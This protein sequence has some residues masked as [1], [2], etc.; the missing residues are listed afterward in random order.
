M[1]ELFNLILEFLIVIL[2]ALEILLALWEN[3]NRAK[4]MWRFFRVDLSFHARDEA[5]KMG[6]YASA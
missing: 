2:I 4:S 6:S 1:T 3:N 5:C